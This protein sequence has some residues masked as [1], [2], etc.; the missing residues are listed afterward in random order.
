[1]NERTDW[2]LDDIGVAAPCTADWNTMRGDERRRFCGDCKQNVYNLSGMSAE[3]AKALIRA[4]EGRLCVRFHR[5]ADGTVLTNDCP[6]GL[7]AL[8]RRARAA[9]ARCAAFVGVLFG[10]GALAGCGE[11]ETGNPPQPPVVQMGEV[12]VPDEAG[13]PVMGLIAPPPDDAKPGR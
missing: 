4:H 11:K 5:R 6:T 1:M 8:R 3:A 2:S 12:C 13:E 9:W 7:R 10:S